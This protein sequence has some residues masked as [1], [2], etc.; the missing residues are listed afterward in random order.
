MRLI[1]QVKPV[2]MVIG[3]ENIPASGGFL[4]VVNHYSRLGYN[5]AWNALSISAV[6]KKEIAFIMSEEWAFEGNPLG[7]LLRPLM[8]GILSSINS[9]YGFLSM[10]SMMEG[11]NTPASRAAAVR[12]VINFARSHPD[13]V[14]GLA[15]EGQDSPAD[16]VGLAPDGGGKFMLHLNRMGYLLL[17][18]VVVERSGRLVLHFGQPFDFPVSLDE[19][20]DSIDLTIRSIV[21]NTLQTLFDNS[22]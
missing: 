8:R 15:P 3:E 7:F 1:S 16:G 22:G 2:P 12:R 17:P 4:V 18:V 5:T 13:A 20:S 14:I 9:A 19:R 21:R 10:P 6:V 11:F